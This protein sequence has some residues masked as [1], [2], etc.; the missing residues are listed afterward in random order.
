VL[1]ASS[2]EGLTLGWV[3]GDTVLIAVAYFAAV[4]WVRRA[5]LRSALDGSGPGPTG[6]GERVHP[7]EGLG[8]PIRRFLVATLAI[9][10]AGPII[11]ISGAGIADTTGLSELLVGVLLVA[12]ATSLPELAASLGAVRIGAFDLAVGN[13]FGSNAFN[14]LILFFAD[15]AYL[16]GPILT[17]SAPA[18]VVAG[19][20]A[21]GLMAIALAVIVHGEETR[22]H[23]L[24]PDAVV[25]LVAYLG[26]LAAVAAASS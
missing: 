14:I 22:I 8:R 18:Q 24:E 12:M 20:G 15:L 16:E 11:A 19:V 5:E 10:V 4:A 26:V 17:G 25:V 13:L 3:G 7:R 1:G 23:R 21:I 2:P 6:W 9:L